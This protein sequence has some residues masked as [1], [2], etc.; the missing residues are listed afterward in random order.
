M[1]QNLKNKN[2]KNIDKFIELLYNNNE[3]GV[4]DDNNPEYDE[5]VTTFFIN[6]K[7]CLKYTIRKQI[8]VYNTDIIKLDN[9]YYYK[10][11]LFPLTNID[12]INNIKCNDNIKLF[13]NDQEIKTNIKFVTLPIVSMMFTEINFYIEI[14]NYEEND[15]VRYIYLSYDCY[16]L[17]LLFRKDYYNNVINDNGM[18]FNDGIYID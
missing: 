1:D 4:I 14:S 5:I 9:K 12:I 11:T 7:D 15:S 18:K 17:D 8:S 16:M 13:F 10:Y 6:K 2:L 3:I